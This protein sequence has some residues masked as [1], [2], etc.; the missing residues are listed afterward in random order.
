MACCDRE[1]MSWSATTAGHSGDVVRNVMLAALE[2]RFGNTDRT[3]Q[4]IEWLSDN[5]SGYIAL[6]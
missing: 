3:P 2:H 5:G 6:A 1:A 4:Q